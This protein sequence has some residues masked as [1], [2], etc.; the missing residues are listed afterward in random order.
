LSFNITIPDQFLIRLKS[1]HLDVSSLFPT[2][3]SDAK[4]YIREFLGD[5]FKSYKFS[6]R[7]LKGWVN[8]FGF[9]LG[10]L[11]KVETLGLGSPIQMLG[12]HF[13]NKLHHKNTD[14]VEAFQKCEYS[15]MFDSERA[16]DYFHN[17]AG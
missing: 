3:F 5:A 11:N 10:D 9:D 15:D 2:N 1:L 17:I 8:I 12:L 7:A 4:G 6:S 16:L 14:R 13:Q